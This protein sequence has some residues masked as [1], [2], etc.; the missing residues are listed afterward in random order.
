[1]PEELN[2]SK[3][4]MDFV[5]PKAKSIKEKKP[6]ILTVYESVQKHTDENGTVDLNAI[7][8]DYSTYSRKI[9][10]PNAKIINMGNIDK[11]AEAFCRELS[12]G[13]KKAEEIALQ[14]YNYND[15][16]AD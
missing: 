2:K 9:R 11:D 16:K 10:N 13:N 8:D 12:L 3:E 14:A 6:K 15:Y 4:G 7:I 1:M 5:A